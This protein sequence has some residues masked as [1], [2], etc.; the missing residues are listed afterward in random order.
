MNR[1]APRN[2]QSAIHQQS[3]C[4]GPKSG[5]SQADAVAALLAGRLDEDRAA[6]LAEHV[7]HCAYCQRLAASGAAESELEDDVRWAAG[8][9]AAQHFPDVQLSLSRLNE[10][11]PDYEVIEE[12]GRGGM[13]VVYRARHRTL[14][15]EVALKILPTVIG[16]VRP[17]TV[18]RFRREARL[19]ARLDHTHIVGVYDYGEVDG[20]LYFA[21][22][23]IEGRSLREL[24]AELQSGGTIELPASSGTP[25]SAARSPSAAVATDRSG[26]TVGAT[27]R[28][29]YR[30]VARW[31]ADAAEALQ[32]AHEQGVLHRDIK[33]SNLLVR[34]DGRLLI[35]DFGL[36]RAT[37]VESI[38][39]TRGILGTARYVSPEQLDE[40]ADA[41]DPRADVYAL[42]ATLYELLALRPMFAGADD[43]EV[44]HHVLNSVPPSPRKFSRHVPQ[45][46]ATICLKAVEKERTSR[47]ASA[48]EMA[49]DLRRWLLDLPICARR[50][51]L[52]ARAGKFIRRRRL[53]VTLVTALV[54]LLAVTGGLYSAYERSQHRALEAQTA[55][56]SRGLELIVDD[57]HMLLYD[58]RFGAALEKVKAGLAQAPDHLELQRLHA[59]ILRHMGHWDEAIALLEDVVARHPDYWDAQY[60]LAICYHDKGDAHKTA[61]YCEKARKARPDSAFAYYLT[62]LEEP[63]AHKAI[64]LLDKALALE[65]VYTEFLMERAERYRQLGDLEAMLTDG[66]R[67]ATIRNKWSLTHD[68][69]GR[70]LLYM[71]RFEEA[72]SAFGR[73]IQLDPTL[74]PSYWINRALAKNGMGRFSEAIADANEAI[75]LQP[76]SGQGFRARARARAGLGDVEEALADY[77]QAIQ[78]SPTDV[79]V[80]LDRCLAYDAVAQWEDIVNDSSVVIQLRPE[81]PRGYKNRA[82][83]Y[84]R[85]G[86]LDRAIAD[87]SQYL[88][89]KPDDPVI[90]RS[91]GL[92]YGRLQRYP[93]AI[94]DLARAIELDQIDA[95]KARDLRTRADYCFHVRRYTDTIDDLSQAIDLEPT[96]A[97][98]WLHRGMTYEVSGEVEAALADYQQAATRT[99]PTSAYARL[100]KYL[101]L[102]TAGRCDA[103]EALMAAP[104]AAVDA[105][106]WTDHIFAMLRGKLTGHELLASAATDD[107]RAEA[108][109]Y[110]GRK[111]LLDGRLDDARQAF[112][113]CVELD[114]DQVTETDFARA[115]LSQLG[116]SGD[117]EVTRTS[118]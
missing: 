108:Y 57:A 64:T 7:E 67:A 88:R 81:D 90:W 78:L 60:A 86:K 72:E 101:L 28:A 25:G 68:V 17:E 12:I 55:A 38:T 112:T 51:S 4:V 13:G 105:D 103:A 84:S 58:G 49:D 104:V 32:Y 62:A 89:L 9:E 63:D 2:P 71:G 100:F 74:F 48:G 80:Y 79:E 66:E 31:I 52:A 93:E 33:P 27:H 76:E 107:E 45:E 41:V 73:A 37:G 15:R 46:L 96:F 110:I 10:L 61:C 114:R 77:A 118:P 91:R 54:L 44:I 87:F 30:Q 106:A 18:A 26:S 102:C 59:K 94:D 70:A 39:I 47:Y 43:R 115:L 14:D 23:L 65:P 29:Y 109:Y 117:V 97:G 24:L 85:L 1:P 116:D 8:V 34:A 3:H 36:A 98:A 19:V 22:Q 16:L 6:E 95:H 111:A 113:S 92:L 75:R 42:G 21:M 11:L 20:T 50:P 5:C 99:G 69:R 56:E 40:Q 35:A 82:V 83:A 53:P